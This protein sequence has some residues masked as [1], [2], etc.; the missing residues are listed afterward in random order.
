MIFRSLP[1]FM[2]L[3]P[4]GASAEEPPRP[5]ES[6]RYVAV[7]ANSEPPAPDLEA[8]MRGGR[9][10]RA[11]VAASELRLTVDLP[12]SRH[13]GML[14]FTRE[15]RAGAMRDARTAFVVELDGHEIAQGGELEGRLEKVMLLASASPHR[16]VLTVTS[17]RSRV[18]LADVGLYSLR[19][20]ATHDYWL[21]VGASI[22]EQS[23]RHA[24]FKRLVGE[25]FG[26]DPVLFNRAEGGWTSTHLRRALPDI[27]ARHPHA[28]YVLIHIGG[29]DVSGYRPYPGGA[30]VLKKN[31]KAILETVRAAGKVPIPARLSYRRYRSSPRVGP[32]SAGSLPYVEKI[33]DPLIERY[34]PAFFDPEARRGRVDA[35]SWF[36]E[37]PTELKR[38]GIHPNARGRASWNRL[39]VDSAGP[40][41]YR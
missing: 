37:H 31:L 41:V 33:F 3:L 25:R 26:H 23:V 30:A 19:P 32:E 18:R 29:N 6:W 40:V 28:T 14:T 7:D 9:D 2:L 21:C 22:Q 17:E 12:P 27:L 38:D 1:L 34:A 4:W 35:Y 20:G 24:D 8:A 39:W 5:E 13:P 11:E 10:G 36:R 16:L 15:P